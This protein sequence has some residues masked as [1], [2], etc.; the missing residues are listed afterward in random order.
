MIMYIPIA[1]NVDDTS[2]ENPPAGEGVNWDDYWKHWTNELFDGAVCA[3]CGEPLTA[4]N[5]VGAHIRLAGEEDNT[6]DAWI[7]L[8][9]RMTAAER[10]IDTIIYSLMPALPENRG[11]VSSPFDFRRRFL[12][13]YVVSSLG[14]LCP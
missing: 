1:W 9:N 12:V 11:V 5:R 10:S 6:K 14:V 2:D 8:Y 4:S 13:R 3:C 7:A